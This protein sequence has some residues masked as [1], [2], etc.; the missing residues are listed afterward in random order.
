MKREHIQATFFV[1][2]EQVKQYPEMINRM[3]EEG[4][5]IGN[6][7]FNHNYKEL[8]QAFPI[9]WNQIKETEEEIR[10]ITGVRPQLVRAPGGTAGHFDHTYFTLL[11]QG[12]YIVT[13]WNVD[14][15]DSKRRGVPAADILREATANMKSNSIVLLMHDGSGHGETVKALPDIIAKYRAHGYQFASL[16]PDMAPVQFKVTA[17]AESLHRSAPDAN[18]VRSHISMNTALFEQGLPLMLEVG[19][20]ELR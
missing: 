7:S 11:K 3:S 20:I 6:H 16:S 13:D 17:K 18:W 14:S 1:L 15:G 10:E 12:G 8:Y 4:H 9:F 19:P 5:V 2:G